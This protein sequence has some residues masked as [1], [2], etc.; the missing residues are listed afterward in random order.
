M[1]KEKNIN[2]YD[3]DMHVHSCINRIN[4]VSATITWRYCAGLKKYMMKSSSYE[5]HPI[6]KEYIQIVEV[7]PAWRGT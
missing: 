3:K 6:D 7:H 4:E 1:Q 2:G 5:I